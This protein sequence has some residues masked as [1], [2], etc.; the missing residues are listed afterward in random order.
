VEPLRRLFDEREVYSKNGQLLSIEIWELLTP[1]FA[2]CVELKY[3]I[4]DVEMILSDAIGMMA[5]FAIA[6]RNVQKEI[7]HPSDAREQHRK[8]LADGKIKEAQIYS[9]PEAVHPL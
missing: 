5:T 2:R 3:C 4:K 9:D 6:T 1:L 8:E 7:R